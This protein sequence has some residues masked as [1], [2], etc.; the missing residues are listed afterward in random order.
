[1]A[2]QMVSAPQV[3]P[4]QP[5]T[6]GAA[7]A[8]QPS[9]GPAFAPALPQQPV[10]PAVSPLEAPS[11]TKSSSASLPPVFQQ[12]GKMV[13]GIAGDSEAEVKE[14]QASGFQPDGAWHPKALT[15]ATQDPAAAFE[16]SG[17]MTVDEGF[18]NLR[19]ASSEPIPDDLSRQE[20]GMLLMQLGLGVMAG[21]PGLLRALG[22][23]GLGMMGTWHDLRQERLAKGRAE[24]ADKVALASAELD[25]ALGREKAEAANAARV[26][27]AK[28]KANAPVRMRPGDVMLDPTT[29]QPIYSAP[30]APAKPQAPYTDVGKLNADL[31]AGRITQEQHDAALAA[32]GSVKPT[33][34]MRDAQYVAQ[35][36]GMSEKDAIGYLKMSAESRVNP[37]K[38]KQDLLK[39]AM[40]ANNG[41]ADRAIPQVEKALKWLNGTGEAQ[42]AGQ[43]PP[44]PPPGV[45]QTVMGAIS[46][47]VGGGETAEAAPS[48][49]MPLPPAPG[50]PQPAGPAADAPVDELIDFYTG[51]GR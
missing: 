17:D 5:M 24:R 42:N 41:R 18:E 31:S 8:G 9:M 35:Q 43:P 4:F 11:L 47:M 20:K 28:A 3:S 22:E 1:M 34:L 48:V 2:I 21:G 30:A 29:Q 32:G 51:G 16:R 50:A 12:I 26:E 14:A 37:E 38:V 19:K 6:A 15:G 46:G 33:T 40:S 27:A 49:T 7:P 25:V 44:P 13:K 39:A 23:S 10:K 45:L 36:F